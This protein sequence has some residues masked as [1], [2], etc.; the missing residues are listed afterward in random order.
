MRHYAPCMV[1]KKEKKMA[2]LLL[3]WIL[4]K[5]MIE[6]NEIFFKVLWLDWAFLKYGWIKLC[7]MSPHPIIQF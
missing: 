5:P 7:V 2:L 6:L 1:G 4:V 3:N